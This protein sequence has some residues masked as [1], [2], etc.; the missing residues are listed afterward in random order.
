MCDCIATQNAF[1]SELDAAD[2]ATTNAERSTFDA[3]PAI[4]LPECDTMEDETSDLELELSEDIVLSNSRYEKNE[5]TFRHVFRETCQNASL[6]R[7]IIDPDL[8]EAFMTR[9]RGE[10]EDSEA[11]IFHQLL[12]LR[13]RGL[14]QI[15]DVRRGPRPS[16][17]LIDYD[18]V[19]EWA[20]R[21]TQ[22]RLKRDPQTSRT[23]WSLDR[24]LCDSQSLAIFDDVATC[25]W[26]KAECPQASTFDLR[27]AALRVRKKSSLTLS[28]YGLMSEQDQLCYGYKMSSERQNFQICGRAHS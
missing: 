9:I 22:E 6:D 23:R 14:F 18:D 27:L 15:P 12:N 25:L 11:D 8:R 5:Q 13:K 17:E 16:K 4:H 24:I 7:L 20:V 26:S 28:G 19:I 21:T 3:V 1:R 2:A 10:I